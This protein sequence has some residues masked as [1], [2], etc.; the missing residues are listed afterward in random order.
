[1]PTYDFTCQECGHTIE[2]FQKVDG[3]KRKKCKK[4]GKMRSERQLGKGGGIIFKGKGF[5]ETDY[6]N[7]SFRE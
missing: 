7:N 6:K 5:Y 2:V 1:M 4:C 3:P